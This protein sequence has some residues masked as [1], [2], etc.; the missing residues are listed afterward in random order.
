MIIISMTLD[1]VHWVKLAY[2]NKD[3]VAEAN[4]QLDRFIR[5]NRHATY[6]L[7]IL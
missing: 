7:E 6:Q 2:W 3:Q 5:T 1:G 4:A